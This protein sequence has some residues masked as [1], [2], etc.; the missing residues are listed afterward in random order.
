MRPD[1]TIRV[2]PRRIRRDPERR[3]DWVY[4][5]EEHHGYTVVEGDG[6]ALVATDDPE[7]LGGPAGRAVGVD[8]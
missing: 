2:C 7:A 6:D 1:R 5:M 4:R 3:R 8:A